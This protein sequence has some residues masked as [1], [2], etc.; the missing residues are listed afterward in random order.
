MACSPIEKASDIDQSLLDDP[1][2]WFAKLEQE[3]KFDGQIF[4]TDAIGESSE[5]FVFGLDNNQNQTDYIVPIRSL[6]SDASEE[7]N[8]QWT[9]AVDS[10]QTHF[11]VELQTIE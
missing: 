1:Q 10:T 4:L 8:D 6:F 7:S 5:H 9:S 3:K 11:E 2:T